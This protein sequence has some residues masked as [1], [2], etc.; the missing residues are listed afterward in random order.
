MIPQQE[1]EA[2]M[3]RFIADYESDTEQPDAQ[4]AAIT[5]MRAM[6]KAG[7]GKSLRDRQAAA[8][9]LVEILSAYEG[10]LACLD[11]MVN[12]SPEEDD[13]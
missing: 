2:A 8:H 12:G 13:D 6:Q 9:R 3:E 1:V 10:K 4:K 5:A 11:F 7:E